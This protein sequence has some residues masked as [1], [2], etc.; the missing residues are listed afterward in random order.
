M[1]QGAELPDVIFLNF[2]FQVFYFSFIRESGVEVTESST[3]KQHSLSQTCEPYALGNGTVYYQYCGTKQYN[4]FCSFYTS[5]F[6]WV[7]RAK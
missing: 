3:N 6:F 5:F 4:T 7:V 2:K 1:F